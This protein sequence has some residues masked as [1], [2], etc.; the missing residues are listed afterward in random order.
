VRPV[1]LL[2]LL[3]LALP[4]GAGEAAREVALT[5]D[6][7]P[8]SGPTHDLETI[9]RINAQV[10]RILAAHNAPAIGF[11]NQ[12]RVEVADEEAARTAILEQWLEADLPLGNHTYSHLS[13]QETPLEKFSQDILRGD[14]TLRRLMEARGQ[15]PRYFRHPYTR[16]GPTAEAKAGLEKFL[17]QHGYRVAPFTIENA[18]YLFNVVYLRARA[19][20]DDAL[21]DRIRAA[22][23]D[24]TDSMFE[25]FEQQA[26]DLF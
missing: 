17:A 11:V 21:A 5:I 13:F 19:A 15:P 9:Q 3:L 18:D 10:L 4:V 6:D 1:A 24:Y 2:G 23:L 7:L 16:T 25:F 14:V 12:G 26:A 20:S 8:I 22:Y